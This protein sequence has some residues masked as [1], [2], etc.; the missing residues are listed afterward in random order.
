[1]DFEVVVITGASAGVGRAVARLFA[2]SKA[3]IGL[4]ARGREGLEAAR[5]DVISRGGD[6]ITIQADVSNP[7]QV[8]L[9]AQKVIDQWGRIDIWINSAMLTVYSEFTDM[10]MQDFK[11]ATEVTYLGYVYGTQAALKRMLP[12]NKGIIVQVGSS[13]AYRGIP[14]QSAY[15]GAKHAIHGF[16]EAIRCELMHQKSKVWITMVQLPALNTPQFGWAKDNLQ[17]KPQPIPPVYQPEVAAD[18]IHWAAHH[19]RREVTV[20]TSSL[21]VI[22]GNKLFPGMLDLYLATNAYKA[23]Q[24]DGAPD[25]NQ[26]VNLWEPVDTDKD[27]GAHGEFDDNAR[28]SSRQLKL[29][30]LPGYPFYTAALLVLGVAAILNKV[31]KKD[32]QC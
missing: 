14:L 30:K 19:H 1:M 4:I 7:D 13:I 32:C 23:Q 24:H 2:E 27:F 6:A 10:K 8:E 22:W 18:A 31:Y 12:A 21:M 15:S 11:R 26:P 17:K 9:A 28:N 3:K 5:R 20:G 16:T 25:P 29:T